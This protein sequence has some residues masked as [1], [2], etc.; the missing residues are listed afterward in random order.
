MILKMKF[1]SITGPRDDIDRVVEQYLSRYEIHLENALE[2]LK[3]VQTL[4]PFME[5]NP[6]RETLQKAE[7][8]A[9]LLP[10]GSSPSGHLPSAEDAAK[11]IDSLQEPVSERIKN[12][13]SV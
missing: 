2:E 1:L 13:N 3:T 12:K 8:L 7:A 11:L 6:Y 4:T 10:E 9:A 5:I